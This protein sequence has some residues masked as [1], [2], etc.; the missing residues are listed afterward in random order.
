MYVIDDN[1]DAK[2]GIQP[3]LLPWSFLADGHMCNVKL[4]TYLFIH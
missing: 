4:F 2:K 1:G 3:K